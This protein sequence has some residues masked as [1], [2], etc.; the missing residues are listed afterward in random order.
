MIGLKVR[1]LA[2]P[3]LAGLLDGIPQHSRGDRDP[4]NNGAPS[5]GDGSQ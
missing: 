4:A 2:L 5:D 3:V 1:T